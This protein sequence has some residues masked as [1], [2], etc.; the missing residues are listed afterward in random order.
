[1]MKKM[2]RKSI[3]GF[4]TTMYILAD[5]IGL[6]DIESIYSDRMNEICGTSDL[7]A[8]AVPSAQKNVKKLPADTRETEKAVIVT[9]EL[10]G[11]EKN[12]ID[13]QRPTMSFTSALRGQK[14][15]RKSPKATV[16]SALRP[17]CRVVLNERRLK[18]V[19]TTACS[20]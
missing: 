16:Y 4:A 11:V 7:P 14:S 5:N 9:V 3:R 10:P 8:K 2:I 19:S 12:D 20:S 17:I 13:I 6:I 15:Q 18:P 1:M